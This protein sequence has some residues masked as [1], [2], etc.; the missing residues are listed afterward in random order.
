[1]SGDQ[2][3]AANGSN[4][5]ADGP[6]PRCGKIDMRIARDG[7]W[8]YHG[9]PIPRK[10]MVCLFAS[11][12]ERR[13]DGSY[14]LVNPMEECQIEVDDVPFLAVELYICKSGRDMCVSFRTNVDETVSLDADHP[15]RVSSSD[16]GT[17]PYV[18]VRPG[19]EA[20]LTRSVYYELVA[21]GHEEEVEGET[22]YGVWSRG[23]FFP[24]GKLDELV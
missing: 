12:L 4:A 24:L 15:L 3:T 18:T 11:M 1:M 2:V 23:I 20:R 19:L 14:W 9:S 6:H 10:E 7:K 21:L 16:D 17:P 13:D 8:F 22:L 5:P